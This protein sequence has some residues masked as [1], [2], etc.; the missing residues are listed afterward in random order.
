MTNSIYIKTNSSWVEE[1]KGGK[2]GTMVI[3]EQEKNFL[4]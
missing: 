2:I 1:G 4:K 3:E